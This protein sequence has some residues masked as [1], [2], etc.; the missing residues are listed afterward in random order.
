[1]GLRIFETLQVI[2]LKNVR[3]YCMRLAA[4]D[5]AHSVVCVCQ[6]WKKNLGFLKNVFRFI[7]F[8]LYEDRTRKYMKISHTRY[9]VS[10]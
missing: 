3:P 10:Y 1:M 8:F 6:G 2:Y 5:V 4:R 7:T 9:A